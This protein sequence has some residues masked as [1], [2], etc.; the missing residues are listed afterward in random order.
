M[1]LDE[2]YKIPLRVVTS[3]CTAEYAGCGTHQIELNLLIDRESAKEILEQLHK[4][5]HIEYLLP[6][7]DKTNERC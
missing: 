6:E 5:K 3:K 1:T 7:Q 4:L 2:K